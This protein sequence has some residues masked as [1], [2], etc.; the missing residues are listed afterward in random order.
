MTAPAI[1]VRLRDARMA[2]RRTLDE[3]AEASGLTKGFLS[4]LERD[5][6][7]ASVAALMRV[8]GAL[9]IAPGSLFDAPRAGE[10]V[11]RGAWPE[12][13]FGGTGL[14]EFLL[15]PRSERRLQ[16]MV[17]VIEPGGGSGAEAY[18][19]PVDVE[20][21]FVLA[22]SLRISFEDADA[23]EL[24]EGDAFTFTPRRRH[25]F[26]SLQAAGP[27]QVLWVLSP[28]LPDSEESRR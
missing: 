8:C 2:Q 23:V 24:H 1:G 25:G 10:V 6:A 4:R 17:S 5:R 28:A 19:L 9:G 11:R 3:V 27:T 21:A 14:A 12:I 13:G 16:A 15:T 22:G 26:E 20:F 18:S 7:N